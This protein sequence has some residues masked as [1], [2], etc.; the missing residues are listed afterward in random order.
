LP[1]LAATSFPPLSSLVRQLWM[2]IN[3]VAIHGPG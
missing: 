1:I 2:A 3:L